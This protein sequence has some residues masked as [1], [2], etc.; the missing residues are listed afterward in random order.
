MS[1]YLAAALAP[2]K[3]SFFKRRIIIFNWKIFILIL[4]ALNPTLTSHSCHGVNASLSTKRKSGFVYATICCVTLRSLETKKPLYL[5][6]FERSINHRHA[7]TKPTAS[8]TYAT[9]ISL[10]WLWN[11]SAFFSSASS[12]L[13][14]ERGLSI[15]GMYIQ[16][17]QH[18]LVHDL[19]WAEAVLLHE[20][21]WVDFCHLFLWHHLLRWI[22]IGT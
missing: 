21:S 16:S 5:R 14:S 7:Y 9:S 15:A 20:F 22:C 3:S 10:V 13:Q 6:S 2:A 19:C 17:R 11:A 4:N 8:G 12:Y 1:G 18:L